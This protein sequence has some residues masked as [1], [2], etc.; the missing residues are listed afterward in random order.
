MR[1]KC[2]HCHRRNKVY[3][4]WDAMIPDMTEEELLQLELDM[5]K[6]KRCF[7][8]TDYKYKCMRCKMEFGIRPK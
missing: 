4:I 2:P 7:G 1:P 6:K 8:P 5:E 3:E